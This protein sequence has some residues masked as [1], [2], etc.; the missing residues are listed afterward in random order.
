MSKPSRQRGPRAQAG[1]RRRIP[2]AL[3]A[4]AVGVTILAG[5]AVGATQVGDDGGGATAEPGVAHVHGLGVN[6]ADGALIVAT[7]DPKR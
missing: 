3:L 6:P 1:G 5:I 7:V 2:G 4:A